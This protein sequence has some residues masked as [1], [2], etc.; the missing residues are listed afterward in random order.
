MGENTALVQT[1]SQDTGE[2]LY[3][4]DLAKMFRVGRSKAR[5][6]MDVLPS[7]AV[8]RRDCITR[9]DLDVY[10]REHSGIRVKWPKRP[11]RH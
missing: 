5:L 7:F 9:S 8:G 4:Q 11:H 1:N 3:V 2:F 10:I 6:M